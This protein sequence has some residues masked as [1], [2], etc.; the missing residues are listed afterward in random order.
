LAGTDRRNAEHFTDVAENY[1]RDLVGRMNRSILHAKGASGDES[2]WSTIAA[3]QYAAPNA[4]FTLGYAWSSLLI[5]TLWAA[6]SLGAV[7]RLARR[8]EPI[9]VEA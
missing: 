7:I 4:R 5:L 1:R 8:A 6:A 3:F 2:L 9:G